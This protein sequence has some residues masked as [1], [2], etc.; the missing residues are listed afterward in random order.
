MNEELSSICM[1]GLLVGKV[2]YSGFMV[3]ASKM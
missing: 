1:L 2:G 3:E